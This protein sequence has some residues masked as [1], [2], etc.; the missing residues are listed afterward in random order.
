MTIQKPAPELRVSGLLPSLA[1]LLLAPLTV[2][3]ALDAA[4]LEGFSARTLGPAAVGGRISAIDAVVAEPN[5]I[6]VGAATGGVWMSDNGGVTW[7][8]VFDN[9]AVASSRC[10]TSL[11]CTSMRR[12]SVLQIGPFAAQSCFARAPASPSLARRSTGKSLA[13]PFSV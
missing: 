6:I 9:E 8:P 2:L 11:C 13:F 7:E 10:S 5:R 1:L 3:A 4:L 12:P